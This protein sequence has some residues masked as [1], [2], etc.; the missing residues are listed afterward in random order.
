MLYLSAS[1]QELGRGRGA[2]GSD[3]SLAHACFPK[4][5]LSVPG[6]LL[7]V[8]RVIADAIVHV[9]A[10]ADRSSDMCGMDESFDSRVLLAAFEDYEEAAVLSTD[11]TIS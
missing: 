4:A 2:G 7:C 8:A 10:K 3:S 1:G 11:C 9:S 6:E 5:P